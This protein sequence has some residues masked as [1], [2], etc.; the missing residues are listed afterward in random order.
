ML[1]EQKSLSQ[2]THELSFCS[3]FITSMS[4]HHKSLDVWCCFFGVCWWTKLH[5]TIFGQMITSYAFLSMQLRIQ[6][7]PYMTYCLLCSINKMFWGGLP[8]TLL[9]QLFSSSSHILHAKPG[10]CSHNFCHWRFFRLEHLTVFIFRFDTWLHLKGNFLF[11]QVSLFF[12]NFKKE[13]LFQL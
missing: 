2:N 1:R 3:W 13:T 11:Q 9:V 12:L 7:A 5:L 8:S 4:K 10:R 6:M